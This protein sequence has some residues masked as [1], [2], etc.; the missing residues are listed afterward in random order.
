MVDRWS[1]TAIAVP[2]TNHQ[3]LDASSLCLTCAPLTS[4]RQAPVHKSKL[5]MSAEK[6]C[7]ICQFFW[8][9]CIMSTDVSTFDDV[10]A[11]SGNYGVFGLCME[12]NE[13]D[14][15]LLD[16]DSLPSKTV[17][18]LAANGGM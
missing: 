1:E 13:F 15:D 8:S 11:W 4:S 14:D 6:G 5:K 18:M 3:G 7:S 12:K 17:V 2:E 16:G 10:V 9:A